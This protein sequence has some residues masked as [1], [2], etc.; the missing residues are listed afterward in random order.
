MTQKT[1]PNGV[2]TTTAEHLSDKCCLDITVPFAETEN[3]NW[4]ILTFEDDLSKFLILVPICE[5][6]AET[7]SREFVM[8]V[9]L[10]YRQNPK[11]S[12]GEIKTWAN[13]GKNSR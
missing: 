9:I 4:Y 13:V 6:D 12:S 5:R 11:H 2:N 7:I 10:K 1:C 8:Q 3:R